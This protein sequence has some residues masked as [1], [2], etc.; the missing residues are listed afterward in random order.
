LLDSLLQEIDADTLVHTMAKVNLRVRYDGGQGVVKGLDSED[1]IEKLISHSLEA[2]GVTDQQEA[3][4]KLLSGFPPKPLDISDRDKSI[5]SIGIRSGD[6]IIFQMSSAVKAA[7]SS[8]QSSTTSK[9]SCPTQDPPPTSDVSH[10]KLKTSDSS[11]QK[12]HRKVV[13]AD[14]SCLFTSINYCMSG[15]VVPSENSNFMRE[16]IASV[17]G[18]DTDKFSD[19]FLGRPNADYC[20]WIL[21]KDAW[22]GAI[23][24]QILSEYFQV[25]IVVVDTISGSLTI[26]GE[27]LNFPSRMVLIYDG[28]HYDPLYYSAPD[29]TIQTVHPTSDS[30]IL[31]KAKVTAEEAKAAHNYTDTAGF[32]LKCLVCGFRMKGEAEAQKHAKSTSHTNFSEV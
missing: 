32:T 1:S 14:N 18:S 2:L 26:F 28:I 24:V 21:G 22:G 25:Q 20:R 27:A 19:V 17:V 12:L 16:V 29:G 11:Q 8:C 13:P 5:S 23:E 9:N 6:T 15:C 30:S 4:I 31:E 7:E 10:K 3:S